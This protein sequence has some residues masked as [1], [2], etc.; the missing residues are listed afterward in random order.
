MRF[1][2]R[3]IKRQFGSQILRRGDATDNAAATRRACSC[4]AQWQPQF[5]ESDALQ[6]FH[7][8]GC[9]RYHLLDYQPTTVTCTSTGPDAV[10]PVNYACDQS[11][12]KSKSSP[13]RE[14]S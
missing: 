9:D 2:L 14:I 6:D 12:C 8:S 7:D 13:Y 1:Q 4:R 5:P 3:R 11:A 10:Q